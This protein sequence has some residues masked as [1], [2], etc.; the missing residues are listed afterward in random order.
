MGKSTEKY[1]TKSKWGIC[2]LQFSNKV[3]SFRSFCL[4]ELAPNKVT[5]FLPRLA[6]GMKMMQGAVLS[7]GVQNQ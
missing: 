6:T 1:N 2:N 5:A 7:V 3:K 4:P